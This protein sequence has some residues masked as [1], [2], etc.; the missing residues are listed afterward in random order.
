MRIVTAGFAYTYLTLDGG[1]DLLA[2]AL[3]F[4]LTVTI[5]FTLP[6]AIQFTTVDYHCDLPYLFAWE[7]PGHSYEFL[8]NRQERTEGRRRD[9]T[10]GGPGRIPR[11]KS[12]ESKSFNQGGAVVQRRQPALSKRF[13]DRAARA[14]DLDSVSEI[15]EVDPGEILAHYDQ[16]IPGFF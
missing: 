5:P 15:P 10:A 9:E 8:Q 11:V 14:Q 1:T 2:F 3:D 13:P 4:D 6:F 16:K 12:G 7:L